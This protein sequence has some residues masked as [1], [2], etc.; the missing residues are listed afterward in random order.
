MYYDISNTILFSNSIIFFWSKTTK[1]DKN[2]NMSIFHCLFCICYHMISTYERNINKFSFNGTCHN[3]SN[4]MNIHA[5]K[6]QYA[7]MVQNS[8]MSNCLHINGSKYC[9]MLLSTINTL[10]CDNGHVTQWIIK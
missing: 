3:K 8:C 9:L 10:I 2:H 4:F 6:N 5:T 7:K 1:M